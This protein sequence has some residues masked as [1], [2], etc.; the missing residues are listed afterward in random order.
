MKIKFNENN[1]EIKPGT[2]VLFKRFKSKPWYAEVI[3]YDNCDR[4]YKTFSLDAN[5]PNDTSCIREKSINDLIKRFKNEF[6]YVKFIPN[7]HVTVE[8]NE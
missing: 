5:I 2:V 6:T 4:W 3:Y 1:E 7:S 8:I